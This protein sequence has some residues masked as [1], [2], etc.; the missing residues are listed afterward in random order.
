MSR[1]FVT[2][3]GLADTI[4]TGTWDAAL[5][6]PEFEITPQRLQRAQEAIRA[7][8]K[9]NAHAAVVD[10]EIMDTRKMRVKSGALWRLLGY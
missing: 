6:P 3:R 8:R 4:R 9:G 2:A 7:F 5:L 10:G 1:I